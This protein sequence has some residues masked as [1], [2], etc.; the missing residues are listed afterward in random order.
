M[1]EMK[2]H[3]RFSLLALTLFAAADAFADPASD[4]YR[5]GY[6]NLKA[7]R[8][9]EAA[10]L[11]Q[12]AAASTNR[13]TAAAALLARGEALFGQKQWSAA[14]RAYGE[15]VARFPESPHAPRALYAR[16]CAEFQD[17]KLREA[18]ATFADFTARYPQHELAKRAETETRSITRARAAQAQHAETEAV[19]KAFE[20]I[21]TL[22]REG[23]YAEAAEAAHR[24]L[25]EHSAH[26]HCAD[27]LYLEADC[28]RRAKNN[29]QA[30]DAYRTLIERYPS[31]AKAAHARLELGAALSDLGRHAEAA[32]VF[33]ASDATNALQLCAG[34][35]FKAGRYAQA[36]EQYRKLA[37][38]CDSNSVEAARTTLL[39]GDCYAG[40]KQ[41][42][43]AERTYLSVERLQSSDALRPAAIARLADLYNA[44]GETNR[45]SL[46][47]EGLKRRYPGWK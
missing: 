33:A 2:T 16:G 37:S 29:C 45:A 1:T 46:T 17:G 15:L 25:K 32:D 23:K 47:R 18:Q 41:W 35:L 31:Y 40:Q 42:G 8:Y 9:A 20:A 28:A 4:A 39:I 19:A 38:Q 26:P 36:L 34:S 5:R 43:P 12:T 3:L 30:V 14:S 10:A 27:V 44:M 11:F 13:E 24:F 6:E 7:Q 21:N 22:T